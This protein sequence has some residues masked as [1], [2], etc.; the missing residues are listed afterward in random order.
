MSGYF[1]VTGDPTQWSPVQSLQAS[2]L[3]GQA[4]TIEV[5]APLAG[6]LVLS[7]NFAGVAVFTQS[8]I[9]TALDLASPV[10]YLPTATG[11]SASSAGYALPASANLTTLAS[12]IAA[13]MLNGTSQTI[14]LADGGELVLN[15][16]NLSFAV[17]CPATAA[18]TSTGGGAVT[19]G[20][21]VPH[22]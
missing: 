21:S 2:Q 11:P 22:D 19:A 12:Q 9:A 10:I 13:L 7:P 16:A 5:A 17:L 1:Q 18:A 8:P 6:A 20:G 4:L 3:T 14:A 15:G